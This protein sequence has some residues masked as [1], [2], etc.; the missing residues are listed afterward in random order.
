MMD[1]SLAK[2]RYR[3]GWRLFTSS[4]T[5]LGIWFAAGIVLVP[6]ATVVFSQAIE[7][8]LWAI[9]ASVLQWFAAATAGTIILANLPMWISRGCTRR[10][11]TVAFCIFGALT[12]VAF[13]AFTTAGFAAE[14]A[15]LALT[16]EAPRGWGDTLGMGARY[17]MITPIY[18]FAG[19]F[20]GAAAAR[21]GGR[22]WFTVSALVG[23][24]GL[25]MVVLPLEFTPLGDGG[26]FIPGTGAAVALIAALV[27]ACA[28]TLR[29]IPVPAKRG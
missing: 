3:F 24:A 29:S 19:A 14:H 20:L 5:W 22:T 25:Y 28:L 12:T 6:A 21:F 13:T 7:I 18:F 8:G 11:I 10:E 23:V 4:A 9:A 2:R 15:L 27:V 26:R 1:S 17:L 16:S